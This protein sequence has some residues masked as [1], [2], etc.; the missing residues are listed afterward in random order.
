MGTASSFHC[1]YRI[2]PRVSLTVPKRLPNKGINNA[3]FKVFLNGTCLTG[4]KNQ[5]H[6]TVPHMRKFFENSETLDIICCG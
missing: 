1:L 4:F 2:T 6:S 5:N 3:T